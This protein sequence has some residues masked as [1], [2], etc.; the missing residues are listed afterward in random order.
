[1][2]SLPKDGYTASKEHPGKEPLETYGNH[3][4]LKCP[5]AVQILANTSTDTKFE[6]HLHFAESVDHRAN[7]LNP[8]NSA[9]S[10]NANSTKHSG[11]WGQRMDQKSASRIQSHADK[12]DT[13]QGFKERA[14]RAAE[15]N[16]D[17]SNDD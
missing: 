3:D 16:Q 14:Q 1:M 2:F 12:T 13:N 6:E 9:H 17:S 8:N 15:E 4:G 10:K 11:R 7:Q 5:S